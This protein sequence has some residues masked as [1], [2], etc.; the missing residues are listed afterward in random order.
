MTDIET[1]LRR[2]EG[3]LDKA[4]ATLV[5]TDDP[6]KRHFIGEALLVGATLFLIQLT[7]PHSSKALVFTTLLK[8]M[9]ERR[10]SSLRE[11]DPVRCVIRK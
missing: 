6:E 5:V 9:V 8:R 4:T 10:G 1:V 11:F 3:V 7:A 2:F